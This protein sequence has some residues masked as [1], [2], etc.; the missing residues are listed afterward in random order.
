MKWE[1][2]RKNY[3]NI[4]LKLEILNSY[5]QDNKLIVTDVEVLKVIEN[6][7]EAGRELVNCKENN[8]VYHT[9][10]EAIEI[11]RVWRNTLKYRRKRTEKSCE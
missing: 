8:I 4:F 7:K 5:I 6:N 9:S 10:H 1:E 11:I 3:P 2:V